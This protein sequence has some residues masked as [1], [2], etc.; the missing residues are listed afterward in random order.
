MF[1]KQLNVSLKVLGLQFFFAD[2]NV[3]N[4]KKGD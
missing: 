3:I 1:I 4:L 2:K